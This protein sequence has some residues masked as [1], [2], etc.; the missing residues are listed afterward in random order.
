MFYS[1]NDGLVV[2]ILAFILTV[3]CQLD[4][5]KEIINSIL[6]A[7]KLLQIYEKYFYATLA[8]KDA[9]S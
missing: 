8:V 7:L 3:T 5:R 1:P 9:I 2:H 4:R 6:M